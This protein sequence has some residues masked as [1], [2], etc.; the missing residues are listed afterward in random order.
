MG[1]GVGASPVSLVVTGIVVPAGAALLLRL[2]T[3]CCKMLPTGVHCHGLR[4]PST[5]TKT[6]TYRL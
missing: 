6:M 1:A 4:L 3:H 5:A 2:S